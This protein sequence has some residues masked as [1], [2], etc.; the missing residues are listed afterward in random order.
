MSRFC[1]NCGA[2]LSPDSTFCKSCGMRDRAEGQGEVLDKSALSALTDKQP[3]KQAEKQTDRLPDKQVEVLPKIQSDKQAEIQT[4]TLQDLQ[5]DKQRHPGPVRF[6]ATSLRQGTASLAA[7]FRNPRKMIPILGLAVVW[8]V[9]S[10]LPAMGINP[11]PVKVLSF[12]TFA[13]G[14]MYGGFWGALGGVLGK[15]VF[16]WFFSALLIP[17]V[18][19]KVSGKGF[20]TGM[21]QFFAG[22]YIHGLGVL[23]ALLAGIGLALIIFNF[24][25]GNASLVNSM[26]GIVGIIMAIRIGFRR[27]GFFWGLILSF[28]NKRSKGKI[29]TNMTI[30]HMAAGYAA[31]SLA[32]VALSV[33]SVPYL[34]YLAGAILIIIS[35]VV[36]IAAKT[37]KE[38]IPA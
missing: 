20:G 31:G 11:L 37:R 4:G 14:G 9:L 34:Q 36:S 27:S 21:K 28:A 8:L 10:I 19:G 35:I 18:T 1:Q 25:S 15:A 23:A 32:G 7:Y 2:P 16:A 38:A 12:V 26:P 5:L 33:V 6:I 24:L 29:P 17:L 22:F 13:Q 30:N 3:D